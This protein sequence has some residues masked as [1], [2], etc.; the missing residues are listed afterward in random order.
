MK[1]ELTDGFTGNL[2][3]S[4]DSAEDAAKHSAEH[5]YA[6][7]ELERLRER[8]DNLAGM[9]GRLLGCIGGLRNEEIEHI[10]GYNYTITER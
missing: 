10:L 2:V 3:A 4:F 7:G 1:I 6:D 8:C 5:T 9:L